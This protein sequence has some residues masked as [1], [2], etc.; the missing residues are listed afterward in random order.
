[1]QEREKKK[2]FGDEAIMFSVVLLCIMQTTERPDVCHYIYGII[3][4][5]KILIF[6]L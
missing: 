6:L 3:E 2:D 4:S 1:M 5:Q